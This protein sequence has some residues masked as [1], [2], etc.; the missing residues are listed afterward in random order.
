MRY[1][2]GRYHEIALKGRNQWRFVDQL[3]NNVRATFSDF[4]LGAMRSEGPR[5]IVELP[6]PPATNPPRAL[7]TPP[8][9]VK[10][11][12]D[13]TALPNTIELPKSVP[14]LCTAAD[15]ESLALGRMNAVAMTLLVIGGSRLSR[16]AT[17]S[18]SRCRWR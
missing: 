18:A 10:A 2:V 9:C 11:P 1:L 12:V 5:L 17:L 6:D 4:E 3:K 14:P 15:A 7:T 13:P 16:S 8:F